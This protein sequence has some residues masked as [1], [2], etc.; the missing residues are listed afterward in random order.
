M[1]LRTEATEVDALD[2]IEILQHTFDDKFINY[3]SLGT[4]NVTTGKVSK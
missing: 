2:V 4:K 1:E 3:Q